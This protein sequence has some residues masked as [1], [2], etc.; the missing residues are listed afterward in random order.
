MPDSVIEEPPKSGYN[1]I[2]ISLSSVADGFFPWG[3]NPA[4]RDR[5]LREFW[6]T[7]PILASA[8]CSTAARYAAFGWSL[9]GPEALVRVVQELFQGFEHGQGWLT[10]ITKVLIDLFSQ[11]NGAFIEVVRTENSP[12][13]PVISLNHLDSNRCVRTGRQLDPVI[14]YDI[15]NKAHLLQWYHV[16]PLTEMP[17]PIE[18]M[19]GMQYSVLT[20]ILRA[21]Q[22]MRDIG[23]YKSEKISGRFAGA[24]HLVGGVQGP[25]IE[26]AL[27]RHMAQST[28]EGMTR[29]VL[30][31]IIASLDPTAN[32]TT[33]TLALAS[34]PDNFNEETS[35][36]WYINQLALGFGGDYQDYAPLPGGS[37]GSS[38]QS[39]TLHMKSR[40]KGPRYFMSMMNQVLN[41]RGVLPQLVKFIYG[42]QDILEDKDKAELRKTRAEERA[43][44]IASGEITPAVARQIAVDCGDLDPRYLEQ[45]GEEDVTDEVIVSGSS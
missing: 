26:A 6:P 16:I 22:V 41:N 15:Y 31:L 23:I 32:V 34:L 33:S 17:S 35:M 2:V 14:Y 43:A 7:E 21:A 25:T 11:D 20:R 18:R 1:E 42:D 30:P 10:L 38:E 37:L 3:L 5:Q 19:R 13:A 44:R 27:K 24:V 4:S 28:A 29:Y 8:L 36:K 9:Q 40:G 39:E 12:T 45:F